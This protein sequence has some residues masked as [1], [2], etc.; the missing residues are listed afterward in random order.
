MKEVGVRA[1]DLLTR[2]DLDV[3]SCGIMATGATHLAEGVGRSASLA[4][5]S[6]PGNKIG[7]QLYYR[8]CTNKQQPRRTRY[9]VMRERGRERALSAHALRV[10]K[11]SEFSLS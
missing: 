3:L 9:L 7:A 6:L 2:T 8:S 11:N 1:L 10:R 4:T 5:L